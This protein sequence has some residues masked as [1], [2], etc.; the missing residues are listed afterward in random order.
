MKPALRLAFAGALLV[1]SPAAALA[2]TTPAPLATPVPAPDPARLALAHQVAVKLFPLGSYKKMLGENFE[3]MMDG[4]A[5]SFTEMP[6]STI[7]QIA[8]LSQDQ[9]KDLGDVKIGQVMDLY[10]PHWRERMK[11]GSSAVFKLMADMMSEFEPRMQEALARAYANNFTLGQLDELLAFLNT[12]TGSLYADRSLAIFM[13]PEVLAE[14]KAMMPELTK[15]MPEMMKE[16]QEE[17]ASLPPPRR[18]EDMSPEDRKKLAGLLGVK[19]ENL[20]DP[21]DAQ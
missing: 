3:K 10:D 12:P 2:Q 17:Q 21:K 5:D 13:D 19:V 14:T 4:M 8:G 6:V 18:I 7:S 11:L 16:M 1:L 9:V 15:K 20:D